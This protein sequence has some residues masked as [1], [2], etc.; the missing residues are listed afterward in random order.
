MSKYEPVPL[1]D[2]LLQD[3]GPIWIGISKWSSA[4]PGADS[5]KAADAIDSA[6]VEAMRAYAA[7]EV[8]RE[9][10]AER[11][12]IRDEF[13]KRHSER[14]MSHNFYACLAREMDDGLL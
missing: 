10:A 5:G 12:R 4:R 11:Q 2:D 9:V 6:I 14:Q 8:A 7:A 13:R 1:P 3:S